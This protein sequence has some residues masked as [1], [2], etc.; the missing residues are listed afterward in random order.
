MYLKFCKL[1]LWRDKHWLLEPTCC[2][3]IMGK[4]ICFH[5]IGLIMMPKRIGYCNNLQCVCRAMDL[6]A[7]NQFINGHLD[8]SVNDEFIC[9]DDHTFHELNTSEETVE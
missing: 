7:E 4:E 9:S 1:G 5:N 2:F 3:R 6:L 8:H